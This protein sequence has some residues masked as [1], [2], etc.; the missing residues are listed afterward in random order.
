M[1]GRLSHSPRSFARGDDRS[2]RA[3]S[4]REIGQGDV[5]GDGE[6][7]PGLRSAVRAEC[8]RCPPHC[9]RGWS[10]API[11]VDLQCAAGLRQEAAEVR[12]NS[13][14][15]EPTTPAMPTT[16]P[17]RMLRSTLRK[18]PAN[19]ERRR[20]QKNGITRRR[21]ARL[22]V[23]S[24]MQAAPDHH[25]MKLRTLVASLARS[26]SDH[27]AVLHHVDA[28]ADLR[29]PHRAGAKRRRSSLAPSASATRSNRISM[30]LDSRTEVGS[31]SRIVSGAFGCVLQ[32]Q[33]FGEFDH[34]PRC[35]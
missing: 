26:L 4:P 13:S 10:A 3:P 31:S 6:T 28:V 14:R 19:G 34:L 23:I 12:V 1:R 20:L 7:S 8:S 24:R 27:L 5:G 11:A 15:P 2:C 16:S 18:A 35:E 17:A 30:S 32:G 33:R 9:L 25:L 29:A 22:L 21:L